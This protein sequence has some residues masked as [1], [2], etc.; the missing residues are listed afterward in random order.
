VTAAIA[1]LLAVGFDLS[2]IASL[3]SAIALLVFTLVSIGHLRVHR[4]TGAKV[5]MLVLAIMSTVVVLVTF[6]FTTLVDEP[7]TAI[8]LVA[9]LVLSVVI[10][11][12]WKRTSDARSRPST[13]SDRAT[14]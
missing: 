3:G 10:D 13:V 6:A 14:P 11:F 8:A 4:E 9:I 7:G 12:G 5:P 1:M 2:A